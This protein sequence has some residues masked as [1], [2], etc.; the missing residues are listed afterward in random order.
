MSK[1]RSYG[2]KTVTSVVVT[3]AEER[4]SKDLHFAYN[5]VLPMT[6]NFGWDD[7]RDILI[8]LRNVGF[9]PITHTKFL[10]NTL[11]NLIESYGW[12]RIKESIKSLESEEFSINEHSFEEINELL[13]RYEPKQLGYAL[14]HIKEGTLFVGA[15]K[16]E[17]KAIMGEPDYVKSG[18]RT[19]DWCYEPSKNAKK[20]GKRIKFRGDY[21]YDF[22]I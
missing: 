11:P 10:E 1:V 5:T 8:T 15:H 18:G 3:L 13:T 4:I 16:I 22:R 20:F 7:T 6:C 19:E 14:T 21:V 12:K 9:D 17:V 2:L